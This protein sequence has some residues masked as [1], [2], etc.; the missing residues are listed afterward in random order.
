MEVASEEDR[1]VDAM[2]YVR[3]CYPTFTI[4]NVLGPR[5]IVII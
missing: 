2:D 3:L 5:G 4:F 1:R